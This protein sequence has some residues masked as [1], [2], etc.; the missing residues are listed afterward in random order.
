LVLSGE[1]F[2]SVPFVEMQL[3]TKKPIKHRK[4]NFDFIFSLFMK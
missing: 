1:E 4:N 3:V 2:R